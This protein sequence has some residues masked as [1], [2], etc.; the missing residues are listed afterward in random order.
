MHEVYWFPTTLVRA[1]LLTI[2]KSCAN[3]STLMRKPSFILISIASNNSPDS[4]KSPTVECRFEPPRRGQ[5][6][7]VECGFQLLPRKLSGLLF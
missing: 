3:P 1:H 4:F 2:L 5:M 6:L 7:T